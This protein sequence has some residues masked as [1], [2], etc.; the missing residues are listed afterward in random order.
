MIVNAPA[1]IERETVGTGAIA[2]EMD[3][4]GRRPEF[5]LLARAGCGAD[6]P[7]GAGGTR[8]SGIEPK[9]QTSRAVMLGHQ[10]EPPGIGEAQSLL[11]RRD[12]TECEDAGGRECLLGGPERILLRLRADEQQP[13]ERHAELGKPLGIGQAVLEEI[14]F[15]RRPEDQ[16][17]FGCHQRPGEREAQRRDVVAIGRWHHFDQWGRGNGV[18]QPVECEI[19]RGLFG[20]PHETQ[21][22]WIKRNGHSKKLEQKENIDKRSLPILAAKAESFR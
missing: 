22:H 10:Q 5:I 1:K 19:G 6:P 13:F 14:L 9:Q 16:P 12:R 11:R 2:G 4:E 15:G 17:A 20:H 21:R 7:A 8:S 3:G 18:S